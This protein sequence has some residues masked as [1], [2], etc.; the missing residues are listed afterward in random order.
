MI[1]GNICSSK[2]NIAAIKR[3]KNILYV[4]VY[5]AIKIIEHKHHQKAVFHYFS[6]FASGEGER[7]PALRGWKF[8]HP[9]APTHAARS[10]LCVS[11]RAK[12]P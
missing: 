11:V 8:P 2:N 12:N 1:H 4:R 10:I 3:E 5:G 6:V 7:T 9:P